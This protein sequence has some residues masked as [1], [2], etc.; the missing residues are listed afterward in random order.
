[1]TTMTSAVRTALEPGLCFGIDAEDGQC[2]VLVERCGTKARPAEW[3]A[4]DDRGLAALSDRVAH[5]GG[6]ARVCVSSRGA[7]ALDVAGRVSRS[8]RV[9][10]LLLFERN[11][12]ACS[13]RAAQAAHAGELARSAQ[14]AL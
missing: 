8:P 7:R 1:M 2:A 4:L 14:R 5:C 12:P 3:F 13:G 10:L 9:E 11:R 6:N